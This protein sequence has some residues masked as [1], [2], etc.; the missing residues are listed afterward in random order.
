MSEYKCTKCGWH[1]CVCDEINAAKKSEW[2]QFSDATI[3][4]SLICHF[5]FFDN[6][7]GYVVQVTSISGFFNEKFKTEEEAQARFD[8]I[9]KEIRS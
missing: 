7:P 1:L 2:L 5:R 9:D 6:E 8:E 3:R 4:K